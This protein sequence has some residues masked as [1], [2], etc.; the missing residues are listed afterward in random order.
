MVTV[1]VTVPES[2]T[3][4]QRRPAGERRPARLRVVA[5]GPPHPS[6]AR[7]QPPAGSQSTA[8]EST[9]VRSRRHDAATY[10]RRRTVVAGLLAALGLAGFTGVHR[11]VSGAGSP[12]M[13]PIAAHVVVVR[14][15]DTLWSIALSSGVKGDIRPLVDQ[16]EAEVH[17]RPLQVGERVVVP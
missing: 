11:L 12:V 14:P 4:P 6:R 2:R 15:G 3:S 8:R 1:T 7:P 5:G 9:V 17:G 13:R 16:L 10:R